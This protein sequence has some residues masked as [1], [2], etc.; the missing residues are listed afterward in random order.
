MILGYQV[1]L[2][3]HDLKGLAVQAVHFCLLHGLVASQVQELC[4]AKSPQDFGHHRGAGC[5]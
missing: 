5:R 1:A 3:L 4:R 2:L